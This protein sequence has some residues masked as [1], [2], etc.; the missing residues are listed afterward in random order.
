MKLLFMMQS[1]GSNECFVPLKTLDDEKYDSRRFILFLVETALNY[2]LLVT[3]E[4]Y[5]PM[6]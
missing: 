3:F 2:T 4:Q 1:L 6:K 5:I